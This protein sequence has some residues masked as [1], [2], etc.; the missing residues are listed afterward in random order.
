MHETTSFPHKRFPRRLLRLLCL[1][2]LGLCLSR[3]SSM[4]QALWQVW[5][6]DQVIRQSK[7]VFY[8]EREA[9]RAISVAS[10][11]KFS[12]IHSMLYLTTPLT[13]SITLLQWLPEMKKMCVIMNMTKTSSKSHASSYWR[14]NVCWWLDFGGP[15]PLLKS[16]ILCVRSNVCAFGITTGFGIMYLLRSCMNIPQ[17]CASLLWK[18]TSAWN[19][20][21]S[22]VLP[23]LPTW[24]HFFRLSG[25]S[26][27]NKG[28]MFPRMAA[29][30]SL[31]Q[32]LQAAPG[33][34]EET[35]HPSLRFQK[36][37]HWK[38]Y[39]QTTELRLNKQSLWLVG[40]RLTPIKDWR[41][42]SGPHRPSRA[43]L[44]MRLAVHESPYKRKSMRFI[45]VQRSMVIGC[46]QPHF[47]CHYCT[48]G[49]TISISAL[50]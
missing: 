43:D 40:V 23:T 45:G 31:A 38:S 12:R 11:I 33:S 25:V 18:S 19:K 1:R 27:G 37:W 21:G 4:T 24:N 17:S 41:L 22:F 32:E 49:K 2:L 6:L 46:L 47:C 14:M 7:N 50:R 15:E 3:L 8:D 35:C 29:C 16:H 9:S 39:H 34:T 44:S 48:T 36:L 42:N 10:G 5:H 28:T 13:T 20:S 26:E 30:S